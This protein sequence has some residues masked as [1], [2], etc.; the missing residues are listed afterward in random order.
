MRAA[1]T[2]YLDTLIG[3]LRPL[4]AGPLSLEPER[5]L[6][7]VREQ[8]GEDLSMP[9]GLPVIAAS[10][11]GSGIGPLGELLLHT[12]LVRGLRRAA[13]LQRARRVRVEA[14]AQPLRRP[15]IVTGL[16]RT[17]TTTLQRLLALDPNVMVLPLWLMLADTLPD[18]AAWQA[19]MHRERRFGRVA[20]AMWNF[21]APEMNRVHPIGADRPEEEL[22][23][24]M[25][26]FCSPSLY[27]RAPLH[28]YLDWSLEQDQTPSYVALRTTLLGLQDAMQGARWLLKCPTHLFSFGT[29]LE[30]MPEADVVITHRDPV[31]A[32]SSFVSM[33]EVLMG[34]SHPAPRTP[35]LVDRLRRLNRRGL[36]QLEEHR[37]AHEHRIEDVVFAEFV[38]DPIAQVRRIYDRFGYPVTDE[39]EQAMGAFLDAHRRDR[40][41]PRRAHSAQEYGLP[42]G[43]LR[44]EYASYMEKYLPA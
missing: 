44:E 3:W 34:V 33:A 37:V 7:K 25:A 38:A 13:V 10:A 21:L 12:T 6:A 24:L 43:E 4:L 23:V 11:A 26:G 32:L 42:E 14:M 18:R 35:E 40:R 8:T 41:T 16:H 20:A 31:Q 28:D 2:H 17:G 30:Q 5:M 22:D 39:F 27:W 9:E 1:R 19:G 15:L 36:A 29:M